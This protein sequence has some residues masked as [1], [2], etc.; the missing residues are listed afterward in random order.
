MYAPPHIGTHP[1]PIIHTSTADVDPPSPPHPHLPKPH[2]HIPHPAMVVA[3]SSIIPCLNTAPQPGS[4]SVPLVSLVPVNPHTPSPSTFIHN[5][6]DVQAPA[7]VG[8]GQGAVTAGTNSMLPTPLPLGLPAAPQLP[9][10]S[11]LVSPVAAEDS[12][13]A[14]EAAQLQQQEGQRDSNTWLTELLASA[15]TLPRRRDGVTGRDRAT[16]ARQALVSK[17]GRSTS[18]FRGVTHHCRTNR[19]VGGMG[20]TGLGCTWASVS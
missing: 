13:A 10:P 17:G 20:Q 12:V 2:T 1:C 3:A 15:T 9:A 19:W 14:F 8:G 6:H 4:H 18:S 7:A 11:T 5:S 16:C